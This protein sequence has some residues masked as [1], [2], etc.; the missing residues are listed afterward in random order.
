V[1]AAVTYKIGDRVEVMV[2]DR[3]HERWVRGTVYNPNHFM[4]RQIVIATDS[5]ADTAFSY[6]HASDKNIRSVP[7]LEQIADAVK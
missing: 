6:I 7:I 4:T 5:S 3:P 2:T 1:A